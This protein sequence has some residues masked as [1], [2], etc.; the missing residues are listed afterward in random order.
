MKP[1]KIIKKFIPKISKKVF[2]CT[3]ALSVAITTVQTRPANALVVGALVGAFVADL[4]SIATDALDRA[5]QDRRHMNR[6]RSAVG[7]QAGR[8]L[9]ERGARKG[10]VC[11][12]TVR[13][14]DDYNGRTCGRMKFKIAWFSEKGSKRR[15]TDKYTTRKLS[16]TTR[17]DCENLARRSKPNIRIVGVRVEGRG[18]AADVCHV[19][20]EY[21]QKTREAVF[22]TANQGPV[23]RDVECTPQGDCTQR[24]V[25]VWSNRDHIGTI[26]LRER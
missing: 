2:I 21:T 10:K 19:T 24:R 14:C 23:F 25:L 4:V 26:K 6:L 3:L 12:Q 15:K 8:C 16:G 18:R 5:A 7:D 17:R 13:L 22:Q 9:A 1:T 20:Y 11:R